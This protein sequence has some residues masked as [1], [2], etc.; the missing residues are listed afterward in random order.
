M[1]GLKFIHRYLNHKNATGRITV[2]YSDQV[3]S[4]TCLDFTPNAV[5]C[6]HLQSYSTNDVIKWATPITNGFSLSI[7]DT[8]AN[9]V[10]Y[11]AFK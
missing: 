5:I 6:K 8:T 11:I 9:Y 2:S 3:Q 4:F 1:V 7:D 10:E